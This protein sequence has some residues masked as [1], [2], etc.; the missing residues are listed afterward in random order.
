MNHGGGCGFQKRLKMK[1]TVE[2]L[3][4]K[5]VDHIR[6]DFNE[7]ISLGNIDTMLKSAYGKQLMKNWEGTVAKFIK[8]AMDDDSY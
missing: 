3:S 2:K 5:I 6:K 1:I 7:L 8:D 4:K